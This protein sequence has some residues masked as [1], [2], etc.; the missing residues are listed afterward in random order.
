MHDRRLKF[1]FFSLH[2]S[3]AS[4]TGDLLRK[5]CDDGHIFLLFVSFQSAKMVTILGY[6]EMYLYHSI[7]PAT[8]ESSWFLVILLL[9][10]GIVKHDHT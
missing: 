5:G 3:A 1:D 10:F 9:L 8:G 6:Y 4:I 7:I 2:A